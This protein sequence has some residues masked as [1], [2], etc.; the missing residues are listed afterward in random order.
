MSINEKANILR[1]KFK[2][3]AMEQKIKED[4]QTD[5]SS[6]DIRMRKIQQST[7]QKKFVDVMAEH[8]ATQLDYRERC[9][10]RIQRQLEISNKCNVKCDN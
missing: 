1:F 5:K 10:G 7:M 2:F 9:K 4:E 6:A 3:K 8:S